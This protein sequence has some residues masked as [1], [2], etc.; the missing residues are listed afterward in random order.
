MRAPAVPSLII[1]GPR[2]DRDSGTR[3]RLVP[4]P[5]GQHSCLVLVVRPDDQVRPAPNGLHTLGRESVC[6][7]GGLPV[8]LELDAHLPLC[9]AQRLR[10]LGL[11]L[12]QALVL[13]LALGVGSRHGTV[14]S[15][16]RSSS[17]CQRWSSRSASSACVPAQL[18]HDANGLVRGAFAVGVDE[19]VRVARADGDAATESCDHLVAHLV[20]LHP[21]DELLCVAGL[22]ESCGHAPVVGHGRRGYRP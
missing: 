2:L 4:Q 16:H 13:G 14:A 17:G 6:E 8:G 15:S 22:M 1:P 12:L 19:D 11:G 10:L 3:R 9:E 21:V 18:L 5:V 20:P 7:L